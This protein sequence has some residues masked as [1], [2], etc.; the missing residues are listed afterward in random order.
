M[1]IL[2]NIAAYYKLD[3]NSLDSVGTLHGTDVGNLAYSNSNGRINKG[4]RVPINLTGHINIGAVADFS[5]IQNTAE[6]TIALWVRLVSFSQ[7]SFFMSNTGTSSEK[8]FFLGNSPAGSFRLAVMTGSGNPNTLINVTSAGFHTDNNW[9][10]VAVTVS[11][12][13][14]YVKIYKDGVET[15]TGV[16]VGTLST[17]NSSNVAAIGYSPAGA[18]DSSLD[19]IGIWSRPL[20]PAEILFLYNN[21]LGITYNFVPTSPKMFSMF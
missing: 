3:G 7:T 20:T 12:I 5:F 8:G 1:S 9:H 19:E 14:N 4:I 10:H 13:G 18:C 21:G 2:T 16:S 6:F 15:V 17:G 11:K